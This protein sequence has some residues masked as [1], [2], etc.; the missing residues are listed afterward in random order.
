M[1]LAAFLACSCEGLLCVVALLWKFTE[2]SFIVPYCICGCGCG[3]FG[4]LHAHV[5]WH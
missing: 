4:L 2:L 1:K 3:V 5:C